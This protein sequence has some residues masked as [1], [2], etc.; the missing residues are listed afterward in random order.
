MSAASPTPDQPLRRRLP[1]GAVSVL[2]VLFAC[3][4]TLL[5]RHLGWLQFLE[6]QA[7]DFLIRE[8]PKSPDTDPIVL[9]ELTEEDI[10]SP[11]LDWPV[12]D[13]RLAELLRVL[14]A[15]QPAVIGLDMWRDLPVPKSGTGIEELNNVLRGNSNIIAIYT[16]GGIQPPPALR[17]RRDQ[18]AFNDNFPG[19]VDV[20]STIPKARRCV[21]IANSDA[22]EPLDSLPFRVATLYLEGHGIVPEGD[23]ADPTALRLGKARMRAFRGNDGAYVRA[24]DH[25]WQM[26]LDFKCPDRFTRFSVGRALAGGIPT[27]LVRGKVVLIGINAPSVIDERITPTHRNHHGIEVQALAIHQIVRHALHGEAPL[28]FWPDWIEDAWTLLWCAA[29]GT[30]GYAIRSPWR[31]AS[32]ALASMAVLA[33]TVWFAFRAGWWLPLVA[34]A[35]AF[36]PAGAL[37]TSYVS[38][39]ELRQRK[40]LMQLFARQV[41][42]DIAHAL[43]EQRDQF[44]AGHRPRPRKLTATVVFTDLSAFTAIS[45]KLDPAELLDWLNE[46]MDTMATVVMQ[47]DGVVEKYIGDAIMAVF[48]VPLA[49]TT[50]EEITQDARNAVRCALAMAERMQALNHRWRSAG[51]PVSGMR[52]GV[53][54]GPLIA[55]SLGSTERQE[56]TVIGDAVNTASRLESYDKSWSDPA[57]PHPDCRILISESTHGH[58]DGDFRTTRVGTMPLKNK[59]EPVTIYSVIG[60]AGQVSAP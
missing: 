21:L 38:F 20:D 46:Y 51:L 55:G 19:D 48:G 30:I 15:A 13:D 34:P 12:P 4:C 54:T 5:V 45:E 16:L 14:T 26:L 59:S 47:H 24:D 29:A 27:E 18:I 58:L 8:Q 3:S 10:H 39:L 53:H 17:D 60:Q 49:R 40:Q 2:I 33:A 43:W 44:L 9:V 1:P 42:P 35:T 52:I 50:Q 32:T 57:S 6:F 31:S 25:G 7:Y 41:S 36:V 37:V 11:G 22:G 56:Y 23:P 28:R